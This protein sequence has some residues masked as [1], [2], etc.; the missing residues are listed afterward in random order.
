MPRSVDIILRNELCESAKPG[1]KCIFIGMLTVVP[2]IYSLT[3]PG[4]KNVIQ[5]LNPGDHN[6]GQ[7]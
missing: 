3:K 7:T 6:R 1:D 5:K 2:D 4:E